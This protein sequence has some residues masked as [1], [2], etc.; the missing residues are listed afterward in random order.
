MAP[1]NLNGSD[2]YT[3]SKGK[4][5]HKEGY[6]CPEILAAYSSRVF[7][8]DVVGARLVDLSGYVAV[9]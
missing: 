4:R 7:A 6:P 5:G 8:G 1:V 3:A 9:S 2:S